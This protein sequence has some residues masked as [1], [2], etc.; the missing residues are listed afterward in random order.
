MIN[1]D[2]I[3]DINVSSVGNNVSSISNTQWMQTNKFLSGLANNSIPIANFIASQA[4]FITC[5]N[6]WSQIL[7]KLIYKLDDFKDRKIILENLSDEHGVGNGNDDNCNC[8]NLSHVETFK[9]F[10][11]KLGGIIPDIY[12]LP[13]TNFNNTLSLISDIELHD[14]I[15]TLGFIEYYYQKISIIIVNYLKMNNMYDNIH[16]EEHELL[17]IKHYT[18][19]LSLLNKYPTNIQTGS[20]QIGSE[21]AI[22]LFDEFYNHC[23]NLYCD[24]TRDAGLR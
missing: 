19:L 17:D 4:S 18:D 13:S 24:H 1:I 23:F 10:I 12:D 22:H 14:F 9:L 6:F 16:Y 3:G 7:G 15:A 8:S 5:V 21:N 20:M 11:T 2:D